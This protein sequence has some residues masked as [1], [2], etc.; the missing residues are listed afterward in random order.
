VHLAKQ[1]SFWRENKVK[2]QAANIFDK[3]HEAK[4]NGKLFV[5]C[6]NGFYVARNVS[7]KKKENDV[8]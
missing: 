4:Q 7:R 2:K 8:E 3:N 6:P 5:Q 1:K